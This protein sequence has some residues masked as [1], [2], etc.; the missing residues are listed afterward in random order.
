M[1]D[2][3]SQRPDLYVVARF[4][5]KLWHEEGTT[6]PRWTKT[7]LQSAVGLNYDLFQRYLAD[8]EQ[9]GLVTVRP[10]ERGEKLVVMAEQGRQAHRQL[11]QWLRRVFGESALRPAGAAARGAGTGGK[12]PEKPSS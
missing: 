12:R 2:G 11:V 4:L 5:D 8:L 3:A 10:G 7:Q 9:R 6:P 1:T